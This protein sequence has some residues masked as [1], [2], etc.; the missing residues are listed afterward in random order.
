MCAYSQEQKQPTG[1]QAAVCQFDVTNKT[2][3]VIPWDLTNKSWRRDSAQVLSLEDTTKILS[4]T[5]TLTLKQFVGGMVVDDEIKRV[6]DIQGERAIFQ[7][8]K[9]GD[10]DV[11]R[12]MRM[13]AMIVGEQRAGEVTIVDGN[14]KLVFYGDTKVHCDAGE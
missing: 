6:A 14:I 5:N 3:R 12:Q 9:V 7:I 13:A 2:V 11:V 4:G 1:L 8:E 10:R